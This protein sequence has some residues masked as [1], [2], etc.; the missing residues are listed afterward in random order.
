M[1]EPTIVSG[2]P[3][4][5]SDAP[6]LSRPERGFTHLMNMVSRIPIPLAAA[7]ALVMLILAAHGAPA[8]AA[9]VALPV[10][11]VA[12]GVFM[13]EGAIALMTR[14]NEGAIAN[15]GFVIG[16][17]SVAVIDSGG[18]V[19]E[20]RALLAAIRKQTAK[21]IGYVINTHMHPDHIFGNA[22]FLSEHPIFVGHQH[23]PRALAQRGDYYLNSFK[24]I[25]GPDL[26]RE[27][28]LVAPT[29]L[30]ADSL[31]L[32]LGGRTL[33]LKAWPT[34][35][36]DNDLTV[37]DEATGTFFTGDL[38]VTQHIPVLDGSLRGWLASMDELA[39]M[40]IPRAVPGH[41]PLITD[42]TSALAAQRYYL[43]RLQSDIR[44]AIA[45][46]D[47]IDVAA[48]SAAQSEKDRWRL[49]EEY[50]ARNATAAYAELEWE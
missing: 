6:P 45:R 41:G 27:V 10:A 16:D 33:R 50:N 39:R 17:D 34:G 23:L 32:D 28:A 15:L 24:D 35:H 13:H 11:Q 14:E 2:G 38:V 1:G 47:P 19:V 48:R 9:T 3:S 30:V 37:L 7:L 12:P 22:A 18:S 40:A 49:F 25:I 36:T 4:R 43:E 21:P 8:T 5:Q 44:A 31:R 29:Q 20:G 46:G 26:M 42:W